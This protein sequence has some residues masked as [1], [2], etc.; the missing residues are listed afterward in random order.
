MIHHVADIHLNAYLR[1]N[2]SDRSS[3]HIRPFY[4]DGFTSLPD[5]M[6]PIS[7]PLPLISSLY[8]R[9]VTLLRGMLEENFNASYYHAADQQTLSLYDVTGMYV[10]HS[11]HHL[12]NMT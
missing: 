8:H 9:W 4:Q 7:L 10:W 5:S 2:L 1:F 6:T 11:Q 3:P 12:A